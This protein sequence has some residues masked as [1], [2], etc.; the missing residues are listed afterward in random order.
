[1]FYNE[2]INP[3][4]SEDYIHGFI[5][6]RRHFGIT[7]RDYEF[8]TVFDYEIQKYQIKTDSSLLPF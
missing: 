2:L 1:M 8:D 6:K 3:Q 4:N 7:T 5:E